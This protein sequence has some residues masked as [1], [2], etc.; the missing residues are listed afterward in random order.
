MTPR[1][2]WHSFC[3]M[4]VCSLVFL[5]SFFI[6]TLFYKYNIRNFL[7][8]HYSLAGSYV[9]CIYFWRFV[10][11]TCSGNEWVRGTSKPPPTPNTT[12]STYNTLFYSLCS[13]LRYFVFHT[14]YFI[15]YTHVANKRLLL[16]II[17]LCVL[18]IFIINPRL[19]SKFQR[20]I[21]FIKHQIT[22]C[23]LHFKFKQFNFLCQILSCLLRFTMF[24]N[25]LTSLYHII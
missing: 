16:T 23:L 15:P 21:S 14:L 7:F 13:S 22:Q 5:F 8:S 12:L 25:P 2:S 17:T 18:V 3:S 1:V 11:G 9:F 4:Y 10:K 20:P 19:H 6:I 24:F